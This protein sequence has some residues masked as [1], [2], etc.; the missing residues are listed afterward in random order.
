MLG[1]LRKAAPDRR[2]RRRILL[3]DHAGLAVKDDLRQD[4][5]AGCDAWNTRSRSLQRGT[6]RTVGA[7]HQE[8]QDVDRRQHGGVVLS[9]IARKDYVVPKAEFCRWAPGNALQVGTTPNHQ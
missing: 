8:R 3:H 1:H 9:A 6:T 5:A 4:P 7:R 2:Q